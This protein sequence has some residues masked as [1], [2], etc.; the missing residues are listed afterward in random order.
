[1]LVNIEFF[2]HT[3][4]VFWVNSVLK[5]LW[6]LVGLASASFVTKR[7]NRTG[8]VAEGDS[9]TLNGEEIRILSGSIHYFRVPSEYWRD[10]LQKL[11]ILGFNTGRLEV[12]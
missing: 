6:F 1:M 2:F 12:A 9:F 4:P 5:M 10:R 8:L 3:F 11:K 7:I